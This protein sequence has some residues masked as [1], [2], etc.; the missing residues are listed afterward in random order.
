VGR[1]NLVSAIGPFLSDFDPVIAAHA[2]EL[3]NR[4][5]QSGARP[6]PRPLPPARVPG[7]SDLERLSRTSVLLEMKGGGRITIQLRPFDAPTNAARLA[8]MAR[9]GKFNGL[10]FHR[11]AANFVVQGGSP[12]ANEYS[13]QDKFTRDE[14]GLLSHERGTVGL[15]TRGRDTGDGQIFINLVDNWRL[16]H[17]YTVLGEVTEGMNLVDAMLEGAVI[18]RALVV[19]VPNGR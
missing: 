14:R 6:A 15:S 3:M 16:D 19:E 11:V 1:P 7:W 2:A 9:E 5:G 12:G 17:T 8:A 18:E 4:W 13:G 10:T